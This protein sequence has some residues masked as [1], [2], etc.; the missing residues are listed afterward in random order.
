[1]LKA[2][3]LLCLVLSVFGNHFAYVRYYDNNDCNGNPLAVSPIYPGDA[4]YCVAS[5]NSCLRQLAGFTKSGSSCTLLSYAAGD[6]NSFTLTPAGSTAQ[7][8]NYGA[9]VRSPIYSECW[10]EYNPVSQGAPIISNTGDEQNSA[11]FIGFLNYFSLTCSSAVEFRAPIF[12]TNVNFCYDNTA[13]VCSGSVRGLTLPSTSANRACVTNTFNSDNDCSFTETE[14]GVA[15]NI[16]Y[17]QCYSSSIFTGCQFQYS[18]TSGLES[19]CEQITNSNNSPNSN[20]NNSPNSPNS[21]S[22]HLSI[23]ILAIV[24]CAILLF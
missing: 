3:I 18:Y 8:I 23:G 9:C 16:N 5:G 11:S 7:T 10:Y 1:M 22:A 12:E 20:S 14:G 2:T 17:A 4:S 13:T 21:A 6:T 15:E 19:V 24:T